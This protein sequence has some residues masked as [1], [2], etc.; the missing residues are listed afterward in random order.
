VGSGDSPAG[1]EIEG[2]GTLE[3]PVSVGGHEAVDRSF[4]QPTSDCTTA[5]F[6]NPGRWDALP[7]S[8]FYRVGNQMTGPLRM[9]MEPPNFTL[10][11]RAALAMRGF[12]KSSY[13]YPTLGHHV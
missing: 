5:E 10:T 8:K 1:V 7:T 11:P 12:R 4:G 13:E 9:N 3:S 6:D 2:S